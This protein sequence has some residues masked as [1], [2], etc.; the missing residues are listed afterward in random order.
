[1][2]MIRVS[3]VLRTE[4]PWGAGVGRSVRVDMESSWVSSLTSQG[5]EIALE[6][7]PNVHFAPAGFAAVT[8]ARHV[9]SMSELTDERLQSIYG[10]QGFGGDPTA[11]GRVIRE[12]VDE[13]REL[14]RELVAYRVGP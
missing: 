2:F 8:G 14:R 6:V 11:H 4:P 1:M 10:G 7:S 5:R 3:S 12:L 13:I 9:R